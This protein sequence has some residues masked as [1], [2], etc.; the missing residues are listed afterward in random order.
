MKKI[1][2]LDET[3]KIFFSDIHFQKLF[4][5]N[6]FSE[7]IEYMSSPVWDTSIL[8]DKILDDDDLTDI[9]YYT[10]TVHTIE[11]PKNIVGEACLITSKRNRYHP[12]KKYIEKE[13][14][15]GVPRLD[16]WLINAVGCVDNAYTRQVS[17]KFLIAAISRIYNPGC[18]FDFM[19]ILEGDQGIGKSTLVEELAG[20]W[21]LDTN[22]DNKDKDLVDAMRGAF[23]VEI[24][25]LSGMGKKDV[26]WLKSFLSKKCDRVRLAYAARTK[27]FKRKSVFIGT[28][29]PSGNNNYFRDDT[30][31]RR[32]W[33][34]ECT[35]INVDFVRENKYQLFAEAIERY[36]KKEP[37]YI[38]N[39][40]ASIILSEMAA[41]REV[42]GPAFV[43]IKGWLTRNYKKEVTAMEL[44]ECAL[45]I[46]TDGRDPKELHSTW[47]IIGMVM[48]KLKWKKGT[49]EN[50]NK[51]FNPESIL[52]EVGFDD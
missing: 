8:P 12:V 7:D 48:R 34:I 49:N 40:Q 9:R 16:T 6:Q 26:D 4:R 50:R 38:D 46:K 32:F 30:G 20:K 27:D 18:K 39:E 33:P 41:D 52:I 29:N 17:A 25:E 42:E 31:N 10:S 3:V 1:R 45:G 13:K 28:Y 47:T 37:L 21:Y 44:L 51:Y 23:I 2:P 15:D 5:Y 36:N 43:K 11:P 14:W 35:K 19:V 22:F 24:S